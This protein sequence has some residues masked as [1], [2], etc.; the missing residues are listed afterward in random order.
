MDK[1][2]I[3]VKIIHNG[4]YCGCCNFKL[5]GFCQIFDMEELESNFNG[6]IYLRCL[7]CLE[8]AKSVEESKTHESEG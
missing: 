7:A 2:V 1:S 6:D 8:S 5:R 3:P 4:A